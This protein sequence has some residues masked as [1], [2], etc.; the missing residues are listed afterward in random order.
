MNSRTSSAEPE[1]LLRYADRGGQIAQELL[2]TALHLVGALQRFASTCTEYGVG[3]AYLPDGLRNLANWAKTVDEWVRQVGIRFLMA[4]Q[5]GLILWPWPGGRRPGWPFVIFPVWPPR[6]PWPWKPWPPRII[7]RPPGIILP[8]WLKPKPGISQPSPL[9]P[10]PKPTPTPT[11]EPPPQQATRA[12][13]P[14][15]SPYVPTLPRDHNPNPEYYQFGAVYTE[16][17]YKGKVHQGVDIG[18]K[19]GDPISA[20][21]PGKVV[22]V[23][24]M[25]PGYGY[26]VIIEHVLTDG[27]KVYSLYAH[28]KERPPLEE[29][30]VI[31][32]P[33]MIVGKMGNSGGDWPVHLHL[34]VRKDTPDGEKI[35]SSTVIGNGHCS[36]LIDPP[37]TPISCVM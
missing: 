36:M 1:K 16:G 12:K 4:D 27:H 6:W 3:V 22:R 19:E 7:I 9:Q 26:Y 29:N 24:Y 15:V 17:P 13:T 33:D 11:R 2:S 30:V 25:N 10:Q 14:L 21:G 23:D 28:L 8:P 20:I 5:L 37:P 32:P 31:K 34:E 18:G 35:D